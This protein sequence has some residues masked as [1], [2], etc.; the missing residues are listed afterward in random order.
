MRGKK[1]I[2]GLTEKVKII[3]PDRKTRTVLA[4]IDTGATISSID[5]KLAAR[6]SLGPIVRTKM[7]KSA[8]GSRS[9]PVIL[10]KINIKG[11]KLESEFTIA[12]RKHMKYSVLVGQ[13]ILKNGFLIDPTR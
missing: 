8:H 10:V 6:L 5:A 11:K 1:A 13:N 7:V 4:R 12:D 3:G 9:R 2:I